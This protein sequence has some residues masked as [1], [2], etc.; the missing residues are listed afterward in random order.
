MLRLVIAGRRPLTGEDDQVD[1]ASNL[2][3]LGLILAEGGHAD[4][5]APLLDESIAIVERLRGANH[6]YVAFG[7]NSRVEVSLQR[8]D[9]AQAVADLRRAVA[10]GETALGPDHPFTAH[11]RDGLAGLLAAARR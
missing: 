11:V 9:T 6:P 2:N 5:A 4:E 8:G 7:L 3:N 10:I 1:L